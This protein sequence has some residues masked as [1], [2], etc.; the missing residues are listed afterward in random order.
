M[1]PTTKITATV[2]KKPND[3]KFPRLASLVAERA[4]FKPL[5]TQDD[6]LALAQSM[7]KLEFPRA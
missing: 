6:V 1:S 4:G 7:K 3:S 2:T 5:E